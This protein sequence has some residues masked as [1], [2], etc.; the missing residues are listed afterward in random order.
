M[1]VFPLTP[2]TV[3]RHWVSFGQYPHRLS[4]G[5]HFR[6]EFVHSPSMHLEPLTGCDNGLSFWF[7]M[8]FSPSQHSSSAQQSAICFTLSIGA[9][10]K[11]VLSAKSVGIHFSV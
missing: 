7:S 9:K 11:C 1:H 3:D 6:I 2:A 8:H 4:S 10:L 5:V